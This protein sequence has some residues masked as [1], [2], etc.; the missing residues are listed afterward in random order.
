M[1]KVKNKA[2]EKIIALDAFEDKNQFKQIARA[3]KSPR[4]F[5]TLKSERVNRIKNKT[6]RKAVASMLN[7]EI[8]DNGK[9]VFKNEEEV[10]LL[11]KIFVL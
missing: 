10:S 5:I 8:S 6:K 1:Q 3:Y 2:L 7:I 11:F 9:F 4:T